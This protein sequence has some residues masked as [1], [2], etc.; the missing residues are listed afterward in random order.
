[1]NFLLDQNQ[2]PRLV[3]L[4]LRAGHGA[5]HVRDHGLSTASDLEIL[6]LASDGGL[7][8]ISGDTDFGE[9]LA[10]T[11][12]SEPSVILL[13]RQDRR[14]ADDLAALLI[15]N[16]DAV[17][18]DLEHGAIVVFDQDRVRVRRLPIQP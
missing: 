14:R 2:S 4:L 7:V 13:R 9:L 16:L 6:D 15:L 11:N 18:E 3:E 1:V 10:V 17:A 5:T 12:R 8:I